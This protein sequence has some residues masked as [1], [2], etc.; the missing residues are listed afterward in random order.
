M[1]SLRFPKEDSLVT[2]ITVIDGNARVEAASVVVSN[3]RTIA[4]EF[5][6]AQAILPNRKDALTLLYGGN[7]RI[8]RLRTRVSHAIG[9]G[10]VILSPDGPVT[11]GERREF[12]RAET[13]L[14]MLVV[15]DA[16]NTNSEPAELSDPRWH[17]QTADLSGSGLSFHSSQDYTP[18]TTLH[19]QLRLNDN[20]T[21][22]LTATAGVVRSQA[23]D[24]SDG[25]FRIAAH[26]TQI[27]EDSRDALVSAVF[28]R[29]LAQLGASIGRDL[30]F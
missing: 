10:R 21:R 19:V 9:S 15:P 25:P 24:A 13:E 5:K 29:Y 1:D 4:I 17:S 7:E 23:V 28:Q 8:L 27:S 12:L 16:E 18:G 20:P 3:E 30:E 2:A 6:N 11:E 22:V 14:S 26:Y